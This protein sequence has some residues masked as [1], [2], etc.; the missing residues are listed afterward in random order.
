M[1]YLGQ[2]E[3]I[4]YFLYSKIISKYNKN[5]HFI[6]TDPLTA[7]IIPKK[8]LDLPNSYIIHIQRNHEEFA[9]SIYNFSKKRAKSFI[10]HNFIPFWQLGI[11]PLENMLNP[12]IQ[13]QY[14]R[15]SEI[16]NNF[17]LK[18]YSSHKNY[19]RIDMIDLFSSNNFEELIFKTLREPI[20][21]PHEKL[22]IKAN[23]SSIAS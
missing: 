5:K 6:S 7:M 23:V 9:E 1:Y 10:A 17:F 4:K 22:S 2:S 8:I 3:A 13:I 15:T 21:I 19:Y 11:F 20:H 14:Q 18:Q 16:K 12:N